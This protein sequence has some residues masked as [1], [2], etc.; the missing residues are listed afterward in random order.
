MAT[1]R[2]K[3][4]KRTSN[5]IVA[6][7]GMLSAI[8]CGACH[9]M[10]YVYAVARDRHRS[11]GRGRDGGLDRAVREKLADGSVYP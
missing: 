6:Q 11:F 4:F 10:S 1:S 9:R 5:G 7:S 2:E 8:R 3:G